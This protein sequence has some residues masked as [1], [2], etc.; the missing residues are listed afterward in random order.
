MASFLDRT[1][2][3]RVLW[4]IHILACFIG[5][6]YVPFSKMFHIIATPVSLLVNAASGGGNE[7]Y[8]SCWR[9]ESHEYTRGTATYSRDDKHTRAATS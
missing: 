5:L 1:G 7:L 6:I 9:L 4:Y 3:S 8:R 2:A